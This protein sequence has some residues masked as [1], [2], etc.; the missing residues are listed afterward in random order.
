M[1]IINQLS[2]LNIK[3]VIFLAIVLRVIWASLVP[4]ELISDSFIYDAFAKSIATG[5]G[6]AYPA[7]N[8]TAFWPV[9][10][11]AIYALLYQ[12]FGSSTTP[13]VM[14]NIVIGVLIVWLTYAITK[15]YFNQST[16][17]LASLIVAIWPIL[18]EFTTIYASELIFIFLVL[19][20]I[21][22]W[23][24]KNISP[25]IRALIWGALICAATY[26]RPTALALIVLFPVL[27]WLAKGTLKQCF[28]SLSIAAITAAILFSP[29]VYRNHQVFGQ[30]VLVSTNGGSNLWMGNH[31]GTTGGYT[32][33]PEL[34]FD[35]EAKRDAHLKKEAINFITDN[36]V[37]YLKLAFKRVITTYKAETIGI[38]WN[39][40]LFKKLS[41][42]TIL[43]MKLTSTLYWWIILILASIGIYKIL[44]QG[45][46]PT[47]HVLLVTLGFFFVFPILTV[48]QDRY[49]MP[50]NPFLAMFAAYYL[51]TFSSKQV[52]SNT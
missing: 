48:A 24:N 13:I 45:E 1:K 39:G 20:A 34:G 46:M 10:T 49:H 21:Y 7:G 47:F 51:N 35:N 17:I 9:G 22:I 30:F 43:G 11:S 37:E 29:W 36:P 28:T 32:P 19:S 50:I 44:R 18:I 14:F 3:Y 40:A 42:Q 12:V 4:V 41:A 16:A 23:G 52:Q 26:V 38:V 33:L 2:R 27:E 5:K 25:I 8:L 6:Y 15:Q 31:E